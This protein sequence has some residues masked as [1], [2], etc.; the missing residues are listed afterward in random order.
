MPLRTLTALPVYNE[1]KYVAGVV[2]GALAYGAEVLVVDD[3]STDGTSELLA[4]R[5]DVLVVRHPKN[6]GY[7]AALRTAFAFAVQ[8]GYDVLVT[9]DCDGQHQPQLIPR[10]VEAVAGADIVSGSR[11]LRR[12]PGDSDP[13]PERRKINQ[14][15][16]EELNRRLGLQLTD[17]FCGFKAYRVAVLSRLELTETGYAMP[18]EV[19]V[20]AARLGL[21]I[22]ELAVPCIYLDEARSFG[23]ALDDANTRLEVYRRVIRRALDRAGWSGPAVCSSLTERD[24]GRA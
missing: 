13:P 23:G 24:G 17:A 3:G 9:I 18:L 8:G 7:G 5:Q 16:T 22:V 2:D 14:L 10:F 15:V 19:W 12:F 21:R 20:E 1:A 4:A 11:Y 6:R